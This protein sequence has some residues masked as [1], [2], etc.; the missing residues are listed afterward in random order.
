[1]RRI[2]QQ[3]GV[4]AMSLYN[5]VADK[6]D[7]L[8]GIVDLVVGEIDLDRDAHDWKAAVRQVAVSAHAVLL[9]HPWAG[10]L[11]NSSTSALG[12]ERMRYMDLLLRYLR[13]GGFS[14]ELTDLAYHTLDSHIT[15]F[16]LWQLSFPFNSEEL[17]EVGW[18]FLRELP[19]EKFPDL[20][21]HVRQHLEEAR[22]GDQ[23]EFEFGLDL[24]VDGLE[25]VRNR[26]GAGGADA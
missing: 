12:P 19:A 16:T 22:E 20:H 8:A 5:H 13:E 15:G 9:R 14:P 26:T 2:G 21:E 25:R 4:E 18:R 7:I 24:I 11:L 1:M 10:R 3:L 23:S 6:D 17:A